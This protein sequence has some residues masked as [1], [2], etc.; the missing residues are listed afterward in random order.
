MANSYGSWRTGVQI[1][2][3]YPVGCIYLSVTPTN[4]HELFGGTW[5]QIQDKFLLCA[6]TT[7]AAGSTGGA[8]TVAH[9]HPQVAVTTGASSA[10]NSGGPSNNTSGSTALT[11]AQMPSHGHRLSYRTGVVATGTSGMYYFDVGTAGTWHTS[12]PSLENTGS[13]SGHTHTLSSHTHTIAH[14]HSIEATTTGEASDTNN[15]P[16]YIAVYVWQRTA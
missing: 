16:P 13:G 4:P 5:E 3:I 9:T 12:G 11:V 6:G 7:Y 2:N 10:A 15:M 1:D 14:T 8:A